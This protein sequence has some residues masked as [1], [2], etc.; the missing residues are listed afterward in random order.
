MSDMFA[1]MDISASGLSAERVRMNIISNNLA[2]A[3]TTQGPD[4]KPYTRKLVIFRELLS[5]TINENE[6]RSQGVEV[7]D[8][9]NS[10]NPFRRVFDPTHPD[11]DEKGI[12]SYPNV[13]PIEEMVDMITATRSYEA[14]IAAF[15]AAKLMAN[16]A[17]ELGQK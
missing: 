7:A 10:K 11:A 14:N 3:N 15:N 16:K 2:N 5:D 8:I 12:V 9:V 4:G 1:G 17:L 6:L 13:N